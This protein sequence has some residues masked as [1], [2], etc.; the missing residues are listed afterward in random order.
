MGIV[1]MTAVLGTVIS[2]IAR[3]ISSEASP[4]KFASAINAIGENKKKG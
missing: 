3:A 2:F 4:V 1:V